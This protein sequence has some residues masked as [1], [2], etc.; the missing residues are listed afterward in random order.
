[1]PP[2]NLTE[3]ALAEMDDQCLRSAPVRHDFSAELL[4]AFLQFPNGSDADAWHEAV[5]TVFMAPFGISDSL[6]MAP[7]RAWAQSAQ[8]RN[9]ELGPLLVPRPDRPFVITTATVLCPA[10]AAPLVARDR[11]FTALEMTPMYAGQP[12]TQRLTYARRQGQ[13]NVTRDLGGYVESFAFGA[14]PVAPT[15][16]P[17]ASTQTELAFAW[18]AQNM[19]LSAPRMASMSSY[20]ESYDAAMLPPGI[21]K[22]LAPRVPLFSPASGQRGAVLTADGGD[23]MDYDIFSLVLVSCCC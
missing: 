9:P 22:L 10:A 15:P 1:M 14:Y 3:E 12:Y 11:N 17:T 16:G 2:A 5:R 19:T 20:A 7:S 8:Q 23:V 13:P 4:R 21:E 6:P 18:P